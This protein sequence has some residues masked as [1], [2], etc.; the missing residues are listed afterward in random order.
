MRCPGQG[1]E[2]GPERGPPPLPPAKPLPAGEVQSGQATAGNLQLHQRVQPGKR[3]ILDP[4]ELVS[5][6]DPGGEGRGES[7]RVR[8]SPAHPLGASSDLWTCCEQLGVLALHRAHP[9]GAPSPAA[10]LPNAPSHNHHLQHLMGQC[11]QMLRCCGEG[12]SQSPACRHKAPSH[13][14]PQLREEPIRSVEDEQG[15]L[16]CSEV[17]TQN[18]A[19]RNTNR[20]RAAGAEPCGMAH[21]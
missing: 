6:Q 16:K 12:L 5:A 3:P 4:P 13:T 18:G 10:S 21:A 1:A 9:W 20:F 15:W 14:S 7:A 11:S 8:P 19:P 17:K 2:R